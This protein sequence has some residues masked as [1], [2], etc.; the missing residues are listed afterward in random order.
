M[1]NIPGYSGLAPSL[2]KPETAVSP[3]TEAEPTG[4]GV[5][6]A[7]VMFHQMGSVGESLESWEELSVADSVHETHH[8]PFHQTFNGRCLGFLSNGK[9]QSLQHL[10][11]ITGHGDACHMDRVCSSMDRP[12]GRM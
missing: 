12:V 6:G 8:W 7:L 11:S 5:G 9:F 1:D 4:C 3:G 2:A 10:P